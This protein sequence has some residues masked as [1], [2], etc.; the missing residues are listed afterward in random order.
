MEGLQQQC[1]GSNSKGM[2]MPHTWRQQ[3]RVCLEGAIAARQP[4]A[5][6]ARRGC[7][8]AGLGFQAASVVTPKRMP[9]L[10]IHQ[11]DVRCRGRVV[12]D[13]QLCWPLPA[14]QQH[15]RYLAAHHPSALHQHVQHGI[16]QHSIAQADHSR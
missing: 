7:A 15:Q 9:C 12:F 16:T 13:S 5:L 6:F 14:V 1:F 10:H 4:V 3:D 11:D 2:M 8:C